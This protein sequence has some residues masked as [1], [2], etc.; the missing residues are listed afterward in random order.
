ML[1]AVNLSCVRGDRPLFRDLSFTLD[2]GQILHVRGE[3]GRGKTSLLRILGG[4]AMPAEGKIRWS[5]RDIQDLGDEFS[6]NLAY[7]GHQNGLQGELSA[8]ENLRFTLGTDGKAGAELTKRIAEALAYLGLSR[9]RDLPS[10]LL[11]QGQKRRVALA[12][13]LLLERSLW[14]LDEPFTALD[15]QSCAQVSGLL[16]RHARDGGLVILASHQE[17]ALATPVRHLGLD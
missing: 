13:L 5:G 16:E 1:D 14:V 4:L 3:N 11:S 7:V 10:K 15:T 2:P 9:F 6:R 17:L 12:R 8:Q